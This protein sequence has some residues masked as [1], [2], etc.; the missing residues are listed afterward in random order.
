[1]LT[2]TTIDTQDYRG[3]SLLHW[4]VACKKDSVFNFLVQ[5]GIAI[6]IEDN[7]KKTP[8][9][10]AVRF[11]NA[12][13]FD[14]I[15]E[16]QPNANWIAA[17]GGSFL[18]LAVL[19]TD[20][21]MLKK[22]LT[23]GIDIHSKNAR[24][25]TA[26]EISQR[27][28]APAISQFL[29]A[30]GADKNR[31]RSIEANGDYMGQP[32]PGRTPKIFAPNFISTEEYEFGSVFNSDATEFFYGVDAN[33]KN[34]IR[35]SKLED[36]SWSHPKSILSHSSYGYNDPF[37][38]PDDSRMYF[39]SNRALDGLG[40]AKEDIDIWYVERTDMGWSE[41]INAGP[42][43]NSSGEEYYISFTNAGTMYF[44]SNKNASEENGSSDQ[45]IYHSEYVDGSFQKAVRMG[46][47][48]NTTDYEADVFVDPAEQYLIFC[49]M[50]SD[51]FGRGDL[52][53][54]FKNGDGT[55]SKS[56]NMGDVINTKNHELCPFVTA[57]G[58]YLFYTSNED[59]Y[60][61]DA[62]VIHDLKKQKTDKE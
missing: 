26:L 20:S 57:D 58:K 10:M 1:M 41:P 55:W 40:K 5:K 48:I 30:H 28:D 9:H 36:G 39:I 29:L 27:I 6:N 19:N 44:S 22:I 11:G 59:I 61:V 21:T 17:Y 14:L 60:W 8:M 3:R 46:D 49:A 45:D 31:V 56:K 7:Q 38:S 62:A 34:E 15:R 52:Y 2:T 23:S 54:S 50:R 25:S 37:L 16:L 24:G 4:A 35:Y 12:H 47:A 42:H 32:E 51:G 53:I 33:G 43:I 13:Y 18:E